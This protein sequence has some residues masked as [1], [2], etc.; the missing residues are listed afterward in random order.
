MTPRATYRFQ[1]HRDFAFA[2]AERLVP[3]LK[4]LGISHIYASPVTTAVPGS[5]HGYDVIDPARVN[6][7]LGA[8]DAL[9]SMVA[10]LR[11]HEMGLIID[12]V[13]N[14]MGV[15][16][17]HNRYWNDVLRDGQASDYARFFDIDWSAP[18]LLPVLGTPLVEAMANGDITLDRSGDEPAVLLYGEQRVPIRPEDHERLPDD[19]DAEKLSALLDRQ[20]Y[21]LDWWRTANDAL[22]WRR[23]FTINDL[24][25]LRIEDD[26]VFEATHALYFQLYEQGLIDGV[27]I[28]H[29]DGL[30]DPATY[31]RKLRARFDTIIR[32]AKAPPG[33]AYIVVEKILA[34]GEKLP[35]DWGV[36]GTSGY[37]FMEQA[38]LLLHDPAGKKPLEQFWRTFTGRKLSFHAEELQAR[39]D[40]LSW[41]FEGQLDACVTA[42]E[43]LA[44]SAPETQGLT[45]GMLRR[46]IRRMLWVFPVYRTYGTGAAAP[47][48]DRKVREKV[49]KDAARFTP[50]GEAEVVDRMLDWLAG[51][52]PG[53]P[54]LAKAAVR[55]FQQLSAP[56]A[57]KAVEDTAFYR[58]GPLLSRMDVGFDAARMGSTLAQFHRQSRERAKSFPRSMLA[59]ATHDHKRGEDVRARLAVLSSVPDRWIACVQRWDSLAGDQNEIAPADRYMLYQ[60]LFGCWPDGVMP[61]DAPKL[62]EYA[63]RLTVW[64]EK[65]L[66]EAK[67]RSSWAGPDEAYEQAAR[68][69]LQQICDPDRSGE[70][71]RDVNALVAD[72]AG[73]TLANMLLQAG[74]H[75]TVPG[76]PDLYQGCELP[77]YS[78]VDPDNRRPVDFAVRERMLEGDV[79]AHPKLSLITQLLTLREQHSVL[80]AEGDYQP[81]EVSGT[82]HD[83]VLAFARHRGGATLECAFAI[84]CAEA[85][86][87]QGD[88]A[89]RSDWWEDTTVALGDGTT[90]AASLFASQPV[91]ARVRAA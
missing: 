87:G 58:Y 62:C 73:A 50:P 59:T 9:R 15:A 75:F 90:P 33:P 25:G 36:D 65:A 74:L 6:Q 63:E 38:A 53:D 2:D 84:R 83:H 85:L 41:A 67:L 39:Q 68:S 27:R 29:V 86:L 42:F 91:W 23:F 54:A 4:R 79:A 72:T 64:Q 18:V 55:R 14:H 21:R 88:P 19:G 76:V 22:D 30:S 44:A 48:A 57:A 28:D 7:E 12:I 3:Y 78:M 43:T 45:G 10:A 20:H 35:G 71:L 61:D 17:G 46:A 5:Q 26:A 51:D 77:D 82:K 47:E 89:P 31:L 32:P 70:L 80:F 49:R 34:L 8:E 40:I 13:P 1:F 52:G 69:F 60:M 16:G 37:D 24:A 11:A 56:I 81:L 66:R